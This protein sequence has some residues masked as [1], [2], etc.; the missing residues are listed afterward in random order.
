MESGGGGGRWSMFEKVVIADSVVM[1]IS[2]LKVHLVMLI[3]S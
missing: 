3:F 2:A 1:I